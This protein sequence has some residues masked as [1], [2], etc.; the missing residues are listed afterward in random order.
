MF[1]LLVA[2]CLTSVAAQAVP[3]YDP[4][5]TVGDNNVGPHVCSPFSQIIVSALSSPEA[6]TD[7]GLYNYGNA[8]GYADDC[9]GMHL[10]GPQAANL[11]DGNGYV[12]QTQML[13]ED[14]G[15]TPIGTCLETLI[16]GNHY[17]VFRQNGSEANSGALFFAASKEDDEVVAK[18]TGGVVSF[19]SVDYTT[20]VEYVS[21]L[22]PPGAAGINHNISIDG[23]TA[24]LTIS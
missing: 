1:S 4:R 22:L 20:T 15:S 18:A 24:I 2:A 6:L 14:F 5:L 9:L 17:R 11:G 13:R 23:Q 10:G 7:R 8:L 19:S 16:G 3:Y 21:G 12:N